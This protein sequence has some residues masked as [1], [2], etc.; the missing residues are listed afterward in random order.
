V[1]GNPVSF[2]AFACASWTFFKKRIPAEEYF[3]CKM[4]GDEVYGKYRMQTRTW[5]PFIR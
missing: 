5:I 1:L 3:L 2:V 4:F